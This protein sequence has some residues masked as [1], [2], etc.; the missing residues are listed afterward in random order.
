MRDNPLEE[1][2]CARNLVAPPRT[3]LE[4][5]RNGLR[6]LAQDDHASLRLRFWNPFV[7]AQGSHNGSH[8]SVSKWREPLIFVFKLF[9]M[10]LWVK[11][12]GTIFGVGAPPILVYV[13]EDW[14]VHWQ[15]FDP[16]PYVYF[17][18]VP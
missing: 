12:N 14:D 7:R 13:S 4:D 5:R 11:T 10:W 9:V 1:L 15:E 6:S 16:F 8:G 2:V 18:M 17:K 3:G